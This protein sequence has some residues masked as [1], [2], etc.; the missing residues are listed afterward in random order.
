MKPSHATS[1]SHSPKSQLSISSNYLIS[2]LACSLIVLCT[3]EALVPSHT[4]SFLPRSLWGTRG[5]SETSR[6]NPLTCI[7][8]VPRSTKMNGASA[9]GGDDG[10]LMK[11]GNSVNGNNNNNGALSSS[12]SVN[13]FTVNG[14]TTKSNGSTAAANGSRSSPVVTMPKK[15]NGSSTSSHVDDLVPAT[16]IA[17]TKLPT[18][19]GH[20]QLRAYRTKPHSNE[21]IGTEPCVIYC[22]DKSPFGS[23]GELRNDLPVRIHDQCLTSEVFGSRRYA[24]CRVVFLENCVGGRRSVVDP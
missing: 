5:G 15:K 16:Y 14:L 4:T 9:S 8:Q 10:G 23:N 12:V 3:S 24:L 22:A 17:E 2:F 18:D 20:F 1:T 19:V 11:N 7:L 13:G 21:F 6:K